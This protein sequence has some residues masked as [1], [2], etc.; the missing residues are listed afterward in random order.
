LHSSIDDLDLDLFKTE[1][2]P[3]FVKASVLKNDKRG[4]KQQLA[5]LQLFDLTHDCPTVAGILLTGKDPKHILFG[6][7]I[8]YVQFAG[9]NENQ[10]SVRSHARTGYE[11]CYAPQLSDKCPSEILRVFRQD[12]NG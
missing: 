9:R 1:Y 11:P 12:R 8:Q 5:S 4:I 7:Y 2:L 10:L 6:S 3:K